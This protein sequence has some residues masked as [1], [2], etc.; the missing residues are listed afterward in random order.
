MYY[1]LADS[2]EKCPELEAQFGDAFNRTITRV[3]DVL[4]KLGS[5]GNYENLVNHSGKKTSCLSLH[6]GTLLEC[7]HAWLDLILSFSD[8]F[9]E[10]YL[11][12]N[13]TVSVLTHGLA[14][15]FAALYAKGFG[16]SPKDQEDG[17]HD[18]M[19]KDANGTGMG[20]GA[21]V[22]DVSDQIEDEDQLLGASEKPSKEQDASND[23]PSKNEKGIEMEQDFAADTFSVSEDDSEEDN[24][25]EDAEDQ[26][27][28]S[29]VGETGEKSEVVDEKLQ[30]NDD[31][32]NL[33][34]NE[35]YESGPSVKDS[36]KSNREFRGKEDS[37]GAADE[38]DENKMDELEKE[39]GK[40]ENQAD[41]DENENIEDLNLNKEEAFA[42]PTGLDL[43][44]PLQN[45]CED[46]NMDEK[47][48]NDVEDENGEGEEEESVKDDT[49]EGNSNPVD[50]T[51]EEMESERNDRTTEKDGMV[52]ATSDEKDDLGDDHKEDPNL[53][54]MAAR[55]NVSESEISDINGDRVPDGG[56]ATRANSEALYVSNVAPEANWANSSDIYNDLAQ[57]NLTSSNNSDLN[58]MTADSS[59]GGKVGDHHPKSEFPHPDD[60]PFHK[61]QSNPYRNVRDAFQEWKEI[62]SISVDLQDDNKES[63]EEIQDDNA[64]EYGYVSEFDKGTAQALGPATAEQVDADVN[65]N[66]PDENT[67]PKEEDGITD[68]E[69]DEKISDEYPIRHSSSIIKNKIN[70]Q[71]QVSELEEQA[72]HQSLGDHRHHDGDQRNFSECLVSVKKSY[73]SED[74]YQLYRLSTS[75]EKM[76]QVQDLEEASGEVKINASALWKRYEVLTT[77]LSHELA[78]QLRLVM[79]PTLAS[80]LQGDYKT[81]KRINMKK[82]IPY[83]ASHY[84]K[85]KIWL[86]RT[87]P[88]KR[89]YQV[90]LLLM[91]PTVC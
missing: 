51:M 39:T 73:M 29:A 68:I 40:T 55:K 21:G 56:T 76:G 33:N 31:D 77:R 54:Q 17:T 13:K 34:N 28:E 30:G 64:N 67:I 16:V 63:Q 38:P 5:F 2:I 18:D 81:G 59:D 47:E 37:S 45:S 66:K 53:N 71:V 79:E 87:K 88:N 52:D 7:I 1:E 49:D 91:T 89:D 44:E 60:A 50:E 78:E 75:E 14:N 61:K 84:Q 48:E 42:D 57:R 12:M 58:I 83:I 27:L 70:D 90:I 4:Q 65:V 24:N 26:Q 62:V 22:K 80:K 72:N 9:L 69:I 10:D 11:V 74:V 43:D 85:D 41:I 20:E 36:D 8:S 46:I 82:V 32:D 15:I 3:M 6:C 23:V 86:R 25:E 19:T 35:K